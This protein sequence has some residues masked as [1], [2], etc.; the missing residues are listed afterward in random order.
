MIVTAGDSLNS[1]RLHVL[2][3]PRPRNRLSVLGFRASRAPYEFRLRDYKVAQMLA[4]VVVD[5]EF[6]PLVLDLHRYGKIFD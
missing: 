3:K 5:I 4:I 2:D 6:D 1:E